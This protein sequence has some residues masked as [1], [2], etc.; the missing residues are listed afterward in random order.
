MKGYAVL[1]IIFAFA[2]SVSGLDN[3]Q[4]R[5]PVMGWLDWEKF[6]CNIDCEATPDTCIAEK[7]FMDMAD[8]MAA[9]GYLDAGYNHV[10]IDDCWLN[11]AGRNANGSLE[12]DPTRFPHGIKWLA[13]YIHAKGLKIGIYEDLGTHTCGGYPGT[14]LDKITQDADTF[15]SWGIDMLKLDGCYSDEATKKYW[16]PTNESCF[17]KNWSS[18]RLFVQ[19]AGIHECDLVR[20]YKE[21]QHVAYV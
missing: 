10:N 9:D 16:L 19:L 6:R 4:A 20:R 15:A 14:T 1:L 3:G 17:V 12:A 7:L 2:I 8:R 5:T 11:K 13:D 21:L 18:F